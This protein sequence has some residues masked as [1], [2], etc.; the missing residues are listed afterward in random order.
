MPGVID[1]LGIRKLLAFGSGAGIEICGRDL[2][3]AVARVRPSG[4]EVLG[5]LSIRGFRDRKAAGRDHS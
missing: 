5:R 1:Q 3:A 2:E 4:I